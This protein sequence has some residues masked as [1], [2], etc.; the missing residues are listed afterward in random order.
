MD[1]VM[2]IKASQQTG[3]YA[4]SLLRTKDR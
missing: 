3:S 1:T 4:G 2:T